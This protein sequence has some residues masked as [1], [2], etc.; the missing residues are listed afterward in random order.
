MPG[1]GGRH[2][3]LENF[4]ILQCFLWLFLSYFM[5]IELR[6]EKKKKKKRL[7]QWPSG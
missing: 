6:I 3:P 2:A 5:N 1:G 4:E 7:P